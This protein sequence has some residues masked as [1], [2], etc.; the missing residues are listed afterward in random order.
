MF[1]FRQRG[2]TVWTL[3]VIV[4]LV[5]LGAMY[6]GGPSS[7]DSAPVPTAT[8][9]TTEHVTGATD[10]STST[11]RGMRSETATARP[12]GDTGTSTAAA[13]TTGVV[14]GTAVAA[15]SWAWLGGGW[16]LA[17]GLGFGMMMLIFGLPLFLLTVAIGVFSE[18]GDP[19]FNW[20]KTAKEREDESREYVTTILFTATMLFLHWAGVPVWGTIKTMGW[21][22]I[23]AAVVYLGVG[24]AWS[25]WRWDDL[26][27]YLNHKL[28]CYLQRTSDHIREQLEN[29]QGVQKQLQNDR[30]TAPQRAGLNAKLLS[31]VAHVR[32]EL[33]GEKL[34]RKS[35]YASQQDVSDLK[36]HELYEVMPFTDEQ[37]SQ[38]VAE[39]QPTE[40]KAFDYP[41]EFEWVYAEA[42]K[43]AP[44]VSW[45]DHK[46]QLYLWIAF[47]PMSMAVRLIHKIVTLR[48]LKTLLMFLV[49]LGGRVYAHIEQ[50][51]AI[52][53]GAIKRD[54]PLSPTPLVSV[55]DTRDGTTN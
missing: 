11:A 13:V 25:G 54:R 53:V 48:L 26:S 14:V 29:I 42:K 55:A 44:K 36:D 20:R 40:G 39:L 4:V 9:A 30:L 50:R 15:T 38:W 2:G 34:T 6:F 52:T 18:W 5:I 12:P 51:N 45:A 16:L 23:P 19:E 49:N 28:K 46:G 21:W 43:I 35:T 41:P 3:L 7:K 27:K 17:E 31:L 37:L 24:A 33:L 8:H 1:R 22:N 47:W 32:K 10:G